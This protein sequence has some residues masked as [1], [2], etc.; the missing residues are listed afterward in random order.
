[1]K[2]CPKCQATISDTAKFCV[3][4]GCNIKKY[5]EEQAQPKASFCPE[6]GT[7]FSGGVFCPECGFD[8]RNE[9]NGQ[10][11][12]AEPTD[13]FG[14]GWLED[15]ESSS[16]ADVA[17]MQAQMAKEQREKALTAFEYEEH[18]DG[19]YTITR[20]KDE[21][22]LQYSVPEGV[23]AIAAGVFE[24]CNA[25]KITLS[26]GLLQIGNGAFRGCKSL[27]E[28]NLPDSL[29]MVGDEAFAECEMLDIHLPKLGCKVGIDAI[30]NTVQDKKQKA[31]AEELRKAEETRKAEEARKKAEEARQAEEAARQKEEAERQEEE[32]RKQAE[33]ESR[34]KVLEERAKKNAAFL[35]KTKEEFL[36]KAK[37]RVK[38][39]Y[40]REG[41]TVYFGMCPQSLKNKNVVVY[42][43][44]DENGWSSGSDG[45]LYYLDTESGNYYKVEPIQWKVLYENGNEIKLVSDKILDF[46]ARNPTKEKHYLR[47][48][49]AKIMSSVINDPILRVAYFGAKEAN[50]ARLRLCLDLISIQDVENLSKTER[51]KEP[52]DFARRTGFKHIWAMVNEGDKHGEY[53]T[54]LFYKL[55]A[56]GTA[57]P[58]AGWVD[59]GIVPCIKIQRKALDISDVDDMAISDNEYA[60]GASIT[61]KE[62]FVAPGDVV[63]KGDPLY[64][65]DCTECRSWGAWWD[66]ENKDLIANAEYS[67]VI[68]QVLVKEGDEWRFQSQTVITYFPTEDR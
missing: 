16:N 34:R 17:T 44:K 23:V 58:V 15:I 41:D 24:N 30:R 18:A 32:A 50:G 65:Y 48:Y 57:V 6:C 2:Q 19:T 11:T 54:G 13:T 61:V 29:M 14:D 37:K 46:F 56:F 26:E 47:D 39:A 5:E 33:K 20:L 21:N 38:A 68:S 43:Q 9:L 66:R 67:G 35:Q 10:S 25:F 4:C 53:Y 52:T 28:I 51:K 64:K 3:K 62:V 22:A 49:V 45:Q 27:S 1:M 40:R 8:V 55:N 31:E 59:L 60:S 42:D 63:K 12:P 36:E 7:K